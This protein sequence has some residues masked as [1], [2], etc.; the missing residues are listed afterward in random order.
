MNDDE[1]LV[2]VM[3]STLAYDEVLHWDRNG[4]PG[5]DIVGIIEEVGL[6]VNHLQVGNEVL[7]AFNALIQ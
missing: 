5:R 1:I 7:Y 6:K 2:K 4:N 3:S